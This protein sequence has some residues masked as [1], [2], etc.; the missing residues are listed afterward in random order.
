MA[1]ESPTPS[2]SRRPNSRPRLQLRPYTFL[3]ILDCGILQVVGLSLCVLRPH[4]SRPIPRLDVTFPCALYQQL[5]GYR[6]IDAL[7]MEPLASIGKQFGRRNTYLFLAAREIQFSFTAWPACRRVRIR[8]ASLRISL[9]LLFPAPAA[10][11][12]S[13]IGDFTCKS[14]T[15]QHLS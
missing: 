10:P 5:A 2:L 4:G 11:A 7:A 6:A 12:T 1:Q 3:L 8:P 9:S 15:N 13:L 14:M